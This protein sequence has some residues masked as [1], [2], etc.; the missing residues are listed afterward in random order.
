MEKKIL[1]SLFL[2]LT[3]KEKYQYKPETG[4]GLIKLLN[5]SK[6]TKNLIGEYENSHDREQNF[7]KACAT[8]LKYN[9]EKDIENKGIDYSILNEQKEEVFKGSQDKLLFRL[10]GEERYDKIDKVYQFLDYIN[11]KYE[12][13]LIDRKEIKKRRLGRFNIKLSI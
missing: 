11:V 3:I 4:T 2:I 9:F 5:I 13:I 6:K 8:L 10:L 1:P 12:D 7:L